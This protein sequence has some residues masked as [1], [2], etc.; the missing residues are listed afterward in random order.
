MAYE[1]GLNR[2][3]SKSRERWVGPNIK[4]ALI[5]QSNDIGA[6]FAAHSRFV[7]GMPVI[8]QPVLS[9]ARSL[10]MVSSLLKAQANQQW[11]KKGQPGAPAP[12]CI[13]AS[14]I[15]ASSSLVGAVDN[16]WA[17]LA[18]VVDTSAAFGPSAVA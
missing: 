7:G 2:A 18:S 3:T 1:C 15:A 11:K 4:Y 8:R 13:L 17:V 10:A 9:S 12:L 16:A 6:S 14:R 5:R